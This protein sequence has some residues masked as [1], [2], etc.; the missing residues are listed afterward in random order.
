MAT[1]KSYFV[2][3]KEFYEIR[4]ELGIKA[5]YDKQLNMIKKDIIRNAQ[6]KF[7]INLPDEAIE[8]LAEAIPHPE[9][10]LPDFSI[11]IPKY[12]INLN[13]KI[14]IPRI[15]TVNVPGL[16]KAQESVD[17]VKDVANKYKA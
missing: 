8:A 4:K 17:K 16:D 2:F 7:G 3:H 9:L 1:K 13:T 12:E 11:S 15:P 5:W 6:A 14:S 10:P